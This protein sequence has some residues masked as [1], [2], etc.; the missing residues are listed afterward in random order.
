MPPLP[1]TAAEAACL[2]LPKNAVNDDGQGEDEHG[3]PD[4]DGNKLFQLMWSAS[5]ISDEEAAFPLE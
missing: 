5:V 3:N 1:N 2:P 4:A